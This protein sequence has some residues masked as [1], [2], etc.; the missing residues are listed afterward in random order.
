[1]DLNNFEIEDA[2][3]MGGILGFA[4]EAIKAEQEDEENIKDAVEDIEIEPEEIS[5]EHLRSFCREYPELFKYMVKKTIEFRRKAA[6]QRYID[7]VEREIKWE[8]DQI[9]K[10]EDNASQICNSQA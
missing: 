2:A 4:D 3:I 6:V 9:R 5:D 7:A 8:V 10:D 1:M